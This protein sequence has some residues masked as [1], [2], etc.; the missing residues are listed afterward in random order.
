MDLDS[1]I[2]Q[3]ESTVRPMHLECVEPSKRD[4]NI[5]LPQGGHNPVAIELLLTLLR[6][7]A[8]K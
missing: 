2:E 7:A 1:V 4:A 5:I 6:S 8:G 3:Y